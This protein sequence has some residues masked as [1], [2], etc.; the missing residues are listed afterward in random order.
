M[1]GKFRLR[2]AA[3]GGIQ[4]RS[5]TIGENC[6]NTWPGKTSSL[7]RWR[8]ER[9]LVTVPH[10]IRRVERVHRALLTN[11]LKISGSSS[12]IPAANRRLRERAA[13]QPPHVKQKRPCAPGKTGKPGL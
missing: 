8:I 12:A 5:E 7:C 2:S 1:G 4:R 3:N 10:P 13:P 11:R 6:K 9:P